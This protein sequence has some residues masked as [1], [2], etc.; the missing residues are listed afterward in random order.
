M[1]IGIDS[2]NPN[3]LKSVMLLTLAVSGNFIGNTLSCKSQYYMTNNMY[4]KHFLILLIV[5]FT[6]NYSTDNKNNPTE[7]MRNALNIWIFYLMFTKQNVT[8]TLITSLMFVAVYILNSYVEYNKSELDD[9]NKEQ[10]LGVINKLMKYR[11]YLWKG[12]IVALVS[13]FLMYLFSKKTE[14]GSGFNCFTC[15]FGKI[16]CDS[17]Q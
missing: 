7:L 10:K 1:N 6:L 15:L 8:F 4:V 2:F 9:T 16:N 17:L 3:L 13:G 14:Y 5:F 11:D 12:G